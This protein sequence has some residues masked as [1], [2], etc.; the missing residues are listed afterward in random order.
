MEWEDAI[1]VAT[2]D[3]DTR[4]I[5]EQG[6][7]IEIRR[8]P[9]LAAGGEG[10]DGAILSPMPGKIVSVSVKAG[11]TVLLGPGESITLVPYCYHKFWAVGGRALVGEVSLVNDDNLDNRF[12]GPVGRFPDI[13]EDVPPLYLLVNDYDQYYT[14]A[15]A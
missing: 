14:G 13:E 2:P 6:H 8:L 1:H 7:A 3:P 10:G 4:V 15:Q 5:F 11:D 12:Y 9:P